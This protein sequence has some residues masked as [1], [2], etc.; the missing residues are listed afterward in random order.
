MYK[1]KEVYARR[2]EDIVLAASATITSKITRTN[3]STTPYSR[4][5]S[6]NYIKTSFSTVYYMKFGRLLTHGDFVSS[7]PI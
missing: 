5:V 4:S 7:D 6:G 2:L 1:E 3:I